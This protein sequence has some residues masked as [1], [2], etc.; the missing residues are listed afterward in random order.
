MK[1]WKLISGLLLVF[2]LGVLAGSFGT[3]IYLKDRFEHLR[4]DPKAR[5]AFIM[6]KL[7]KE[8]ELTPDQKIKVEKIVEQMG[9][10]RREFFLKNRP[11]IKKIMDEGFAQIRKELN[12]DQQKK[13]DVLREEFEKR[14]K[15]R[16]SSRFHQ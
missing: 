14:R 15:A 3:R 5:Q 10:K 2:V 16:Y 9:E 6:R 13:L 12:S 11:E 4:K 8:L 7:S 1:R